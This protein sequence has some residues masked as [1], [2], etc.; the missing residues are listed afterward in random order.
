MEAICQR[1]FIM[2]IVGKS[3]P[4]PMRVRAERMRVFDAGYEAGFRA[5]MWHLVSD[6]RMTFDE[7]HQFLWDKKRTEVEPKALEAVKK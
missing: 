5:A 2:S 1:L 7:A 6:G 4:E 3:M